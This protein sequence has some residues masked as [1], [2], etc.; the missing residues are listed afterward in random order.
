MA[1]GKITQLAE[2][3]WFHH[4]YPEAAVQ[5]ADVRELVQQ[6]AHRV[7]GDDMFYAMIRVVRPA[8]DYELLGPWNIEPTV[9]RRADNRISIG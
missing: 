3:L 4:G 6:S 7:F 9:E 8:A 1:E 5:I 2:P